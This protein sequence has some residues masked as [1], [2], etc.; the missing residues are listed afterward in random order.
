MRRFILL[1]LLILAVPAPAEAWRYYTNSSGDPVHWATGGPCTIAFQY[2]PKGIDSIPGMKEFTRFD[3]AMD[4][5]N[6]NPCT[7]V[8]LVVDGVDDACEAF[9]FP[10]ADQNCIVVSHDLW[11]HDNHGAAMLTILSYKPSS[12]H[13][14]DVDIDI[15]EKDFDFALDADGI[16]NPEDFVDFGFAATHEIGHVYGLDHPPCGPDDPPSIMCSDGEIYLPDEHPME[17]QED[18][19]AGVCS[20]YAR[21]LYTCDDSPPEPEP[22]FEAEPDLQPE[23]NPEAAPVDPGGGNDKPCGAC[24]ATSAAPTGPVLPLLLLSLLVVLRR[25][26]SA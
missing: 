8:Q 14:Q 9:A 6:A 23:P 7:D 24:A 3:D 20:V 4:Q 17:P 11:D 22:E 13:L 15:N 5:W 26:R 18:D 16:E 10:G 1:L 12:G 21:N 25:R 2:H 19:F